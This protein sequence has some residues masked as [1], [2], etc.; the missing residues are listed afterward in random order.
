MKRVGLFIGVNKYSHGISKLEFAKNDADKLSDCFK[1][2]GYEVERLLNEEVTYDGILKKIDEIKGG[3]KSG[4]LFVLYFAGHGVEIAGRHCL[5]CAD[6]DDQM[7]TL[8][9]KMPLQDLIRYSAKSGIH[10]LFIL[11]SCRRELLA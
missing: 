2:K 5:L 11:D 4:D 1:G 10:R 6:A 8:K 7:D 3:L 9:G